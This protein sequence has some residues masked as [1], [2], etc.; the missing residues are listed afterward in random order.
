LSPP[1]QNPIR[2]DESTQADAIDRFGEI[3]R[4]IQENQIEE[5]IVEEIEDQSEMNSEITGHDDGLR[6]SHRYNLRS[7]NRG[8]S[9]KEY[10]LHITVN[11]AIKKFGKTAFRVIADELQQMLDKHVWTPVHD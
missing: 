3:L 9:T 5:E 6:P 4:K 2:A 1:N 7:R 10:G 8:E 11:T